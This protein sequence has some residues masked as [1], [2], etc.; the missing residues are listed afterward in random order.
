MEGPRKL[1]EL[2]GWCR[3]FAERAGDPAIWHPREGEMM[4]AV[5]VSFARPRKTNRSPRQGWPGSG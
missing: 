3:D 1:R 2:A 5:G 4:G